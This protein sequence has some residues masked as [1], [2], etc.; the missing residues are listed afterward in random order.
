[1]RDSFDVAVVGLGIM[2]SAIAAELA[3]RGARVIGFE[4]H[5]PAHDRG[6]STGQSRIFRRS[7]PDYPEYATQTRAAMRSWKELHAATGIDLFL[8]TSG[9]R[10]GRAGGAAMTAAKAA[11]EQ[12]AAP[13]KLLGADLLR[14]L[15]PHLHVDRGEAGLLDIEAGVLLAEPCLTAY[16]QVAVRHGAELRFGA[17]VRLERLV[18]SWSEHG[19][20][21]F[22]PAVRARHL[23]LAVGAWLGSA[24]AGLRWPAVTV[25]R[26]VSHWFSACGRTDAISAPSF[27]FVEWVDEPG[28]F[29]VMPAIAGL[30]KAKTR[31]SDEPADPVAGPRPPDA[32]EAEDVRQRLERALGIAFRSV[33]ARAD[34]YTNTASGALEVTPHPQIPHLSVVTACSGHGFKLA[35][36]VAARAAELCSLSAGGFTA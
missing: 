24:P 1:V 4:A 22:S 25:Q 28:E 19:A 13:Y 5:W 33:R 3:R 9:L 11:A 35:P 18:D 8:P 10:I 29:C 34:M 23:V 16:Q 7:H 30:V 32:A 14:R 27:P 17:P 6:A 21:P 31:Y 36:V 2:G 20:L 26:T 15:Y 12:A